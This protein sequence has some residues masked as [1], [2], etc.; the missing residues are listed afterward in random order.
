MFLDVVKHVTDEYP[1]IWFKLSGFVCIV[2]NVETA[3]Q[4]AKLGILKRLKVLVFFTHY[5]YFFIQY[6]VVIEQSV[7][8]CFLSVQ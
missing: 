1:Q 2:F 4:N 8:T 5:Q 3:L 6:F 7:K